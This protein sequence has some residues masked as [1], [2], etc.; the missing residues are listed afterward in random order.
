MPVEI[1]ESAQAGVIEVP[2]S[3][4]VTSADYQRFVPVLEQLIERHG[5]ISI[6][7]RL[8][9]FQGWDAGGLWEDIKFDVKHFDDIERLAI[10]GE[11]RWHEAMAV[12]CRPF[13]T[14]KIRYFEQ[15]ELAE[16]RVWIAAS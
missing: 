9:D 2:L 15:D 11:S 12:F 5:K 7:V 6:L 14:A 16:A 4:K 1:Q 13:T 3:G 8:L 10:V